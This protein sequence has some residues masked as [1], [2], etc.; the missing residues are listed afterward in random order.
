MAIV[1]WPS[2]V[3]GFLATTIQ[4]ALLVPSRRYN[5]ALG[6]RQSFPRPAISLWMTI[7][8]ES[9]M[10]EGQFTSFY[11]FY[12]NTLRN[13][14]YSIRYVHPIWTG[15]IIGQIIRFNNYRKISAKHW[16][17]SYSVRYR[18]PPYDA[19]YTEG[20]NWPTNFPSHWLISGTSNQEPVQ[21]VESS[22]EL[23]QYQERRPRSYNAPVS[24]RRSTIL[25]DSQY[26][27]FWRWYQY[28]LANGA[29]QFAHPDGNVYRM[30]GNIS[31]R[32]LGLNKWYFNMAMEQ[33][34]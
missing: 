10:S 27:D 9:N 32:C 3:P 14:T 18:I 4:E 13:G 22:P 7:F 17:V 20:S 30:L 26:Q 21:Y 34:R 23:Q 29:L 33:L 11:S 8:G 19:A 16:R 2:D 31:V 5:A 25:N 15:D 24:V 6:T 28:G 1:S 12:R